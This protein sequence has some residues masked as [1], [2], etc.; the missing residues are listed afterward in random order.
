MMRQRGCSDHPEVD[1]PDRISAF[2]PPMPAPP[3]ARHPPG[4]RSEN[5][6]T[7][8]SGAGVA[9]GIAMLKID[10]QPWRGRRAVHANDGEG[11]EPRRN[12]NDWQ[13]AMNA[14]AYAAPFAGDAGVMRWR[15]MQEGG[16]RRGN[17]KPRMQRRLRGLPGAERVS[18]TRPASNDA[19]YCSPSPLICGSADD[20]PG[21]SRPTCVYT[22]SLSRV[23]VM[24]RLRIVSWPIRSRG[25]NVDATFSIDRRSG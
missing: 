21:V 8:V 19:A 10:R 12:S 16:K 22:R 25:E 23:S 5:S 24:S 20:S 18:A 6:R 15:E 3:A 1:S 2:R 17:G 14:A 13:L 4:S 11:H 9:A 7:P